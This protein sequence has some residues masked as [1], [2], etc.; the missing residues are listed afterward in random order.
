MNIEK[1]D[2]LVTLAE[3]AKLLRCSRSL[4]YR[5]IEQKYPLPVYRVGTLIRFRA[6]ELIE[7]FKSGAFEKTRQEK[8]D[9][10]VNRF[11]GEIK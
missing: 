9:A 5:L 2:T 3:A 1:E 6:T 4:L 11:T 7:F 10:K 8:I